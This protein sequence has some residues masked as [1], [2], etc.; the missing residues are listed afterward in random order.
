[1]SYK[2]NQRSILKHSRFTKSNIFKKTN[3]FCFRKTLKSKQE[4]I[5][6]PSFS[7]LGGNRKDPLNL[8]ELIQQSIMNNDHIETNLHPNDRQVEILLQPNIFDPLCLDSS[9][10]NSNNQQTQYNWYYDQQI[11]KS[12]KH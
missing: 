9:S 8:N 10:Y 1:M 2:H 6:F 4:F 5:Q 3:H 11:P 7:L 12:N